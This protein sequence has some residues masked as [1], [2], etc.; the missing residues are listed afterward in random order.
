MMRIITKVALAAAG[1]AAMAVGLGYLAMT[2]PR[3]EAAQLLYA[4]A[5]TVAAIGLLAGIGVWLGHYLQEVLRVS[6]YLA[7]ETDEAKTRLLW[8]SALQ[9]QNADLIFG[10]KET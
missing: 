10:P 6:R 7:D 3:P 2:A 9:G 8:R 4:H 5:G 1:P